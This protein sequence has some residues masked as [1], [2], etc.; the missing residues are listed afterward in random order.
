MPSR[1]VYPNAPLRLVTS[2]FRFPLSP[3]LSRDDVLGELAGVLGDALPIVEVASPPGFTLSVGVESPLRPGASSGGYRF[4][5]RDR[6]A[7]VTVAPTRIAIETTKYAHWE[8]FRDTVV[9]PA[10]EGV[11]GELGAIAG[12]DRVGLRYIN[13]IRV[14]KGSLRPEDWTDYVS[15]DLVAMMRLADGSLVQTAQGA[16]HLLTPSNDE[17]LMRFGTM[18]GFMVADSGPLALPTPIRDGAFFLVDID[19]YWA[20]SATLDEF[21]VSDALAISD[22]LHQPVNQLFEHSISEKLREEVL[23][24]GPS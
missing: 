20:R 13:E 5:T 6:M 4:M 21:S 24:V 9:R 22:R 16:L 15:E 17:I 11:G 2:E 23:R 3:R 1:E 8:T 14:V 12:L 7:A 10:L 18:E 19:S